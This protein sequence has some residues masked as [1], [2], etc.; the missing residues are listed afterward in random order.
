MYTST[1]RSSEVSQT[2]DLVSIAVFLGVRECTLV[3]RDHVTSVK[4][5]IFLSKQCFFSVGECTL[6]PRDQVTSVKQLILLA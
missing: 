5:L 2:T 1:K 4:Q 3:S 6:V